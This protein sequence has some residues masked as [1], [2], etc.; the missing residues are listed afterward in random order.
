M[1]VSDRRL[2]MAYEGGGPDADPGVPANPNEQSALSAYLQMLYRRKWLILICMLVGILVALFVTFSTTRLYRATT[3]LEI[4]REAS[5]VVENKGVE[6]PASVGSAEF[7][8]T[9]YGLLQSRALSETVVRRL[10]LGQNPTIL[11]GYSGD[12]SAAEPVTTAQGRADQQ[13]QAVNIVMDNI[14]VTPQR[15]SGLVEVSFA[16]PDPELSARVANAIAESYIESSLSRRFNATAYAR[17]FLEGQI[18]QVRGRLEASERALVAYANQQGIITIDRTGADGQSEGAQSLSSID[19]Q[20]LN[21]ALASARADRI[22]AEANA[23]GSSSAAQSRVL[24]D[25][26][27]TAL[28]QSRAE[29]A[30]QRARLLTQFQEDYPQV[31]AV[32]N[33]IAELDRQLASQSSAV[34]NSVSADYRSAVQRE[35]A[36]EARVNQLKQNVLNDRER[37]IQ[38]NILQREA[39]T[40]RQQYQDLLQ[41]YKEVGVASGVGAN[42]VAVVDPAVVPGGPFTPRPMLNLLIGALIGLFGGA[43]VAFVLAQLDE[44]IA[45]PHELEPKIGIPL[46]GSIPKKSGDI[47]ILEELEDRKSPIVEAY[48]SVQ[49]ALRFSTSHGAPRSLMVTSARAAE[50]KSTTSIALAENFARLGKRTVLID[51]DMR[52]PS[53]HR[54]LNLS[55]ATGLSNALAGS[56]E[57]MSHLQT[58][59]ETGLQVMTAGPLPPNPA[60]LLANTRLADI[61]ATLLEQFDHVVLDGP[62]VL[63]LADSPLVAHSVEATVFVVAANET[64]AKAAQIAIARLRDAHAHVI[65]AVLTKFNSQQVGYDYGYSYDYGQ[66]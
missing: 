42:N 56:D 59:E 2:G 61:V 25:G 66:R 52:N 17:E 36:L 4:A 23:A 51:S 48:N 40:N 57:L 5:R 64:R 47:E 29:L 8:Q 22:Q 62:P 54:V 24:S 49:T 32:T 58:S 27:L 41:R 50:G 33:Q 30:G 14:V 26:A 39:D 18:E 45:S 13:R 55:N 34:R 35:S 37:Q 15:N 3:T 53:I 31:Q 11:Y 16:S 28:R 10:R 12:E 9:Q 6:P 44:T 21:Q 65:G 46:L 7:Y 20:A 38:Y 1:N 43:A 63:G 60:E 19:L